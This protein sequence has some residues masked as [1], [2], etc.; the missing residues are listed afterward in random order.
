MDAHL[1][2]ELKRQSR[3]PVPAPEASLSPLILCRSH[4][5]GV[6]F[7][8]HQNSAVEMMYVCAGSIT[9]VIEGSE[10]RLNAG[11]LLLMNQYTAHAICPS[12]PEDLAVNLSIRP[13]FFDQTD[14]MFAQRTVLSDFLADLLRR[15][16]SW[17]QYLCFKVSDH[18]PIHNLMEVLLVSLFPRSDPGHS[19]PPQPTDPQ[20]IQTCVAMIF[21]F[22]SK[23]L[24]SLDCHAPLNHDQATLHALQSYVEEHYRDAGLREL[25][26]ILNCSESALSRQIR[27]LTGKTFTTL[28]Q[29]RRFE[30]AK[31]LL[32]ETMIPVSDIAASVGYENF[33]YFYQCFRR[34]FGC[35]PNQYRR[36]HPPIHRAPPH[37]E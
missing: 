19:G 36:Q 2:D 31:H 34:R 6:S 28:V 12:G 26:G 8:L 5:Q 11:D 21:Y 22:I 3:S 25:A 37:P 23:D 14:A 18:L 16:V 10:V 13:S 27:R 1:L 30:R 7:P 4:P 24:S 35:S 17:G 20:I 32:E 9:H 29:D 15:S 33:S